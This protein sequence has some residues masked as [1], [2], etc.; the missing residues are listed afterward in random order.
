MDYI[1]VKQAAE[2]WDVSDRRV[3]QHCK[4]GRIPGAVQPAR[5]WLIPKDTEKPEDMRKYGK[6]RPP[7]KEKN[8]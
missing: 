4:N 8:A 5:D 6:G 1:T 2:K 7:K 3:L